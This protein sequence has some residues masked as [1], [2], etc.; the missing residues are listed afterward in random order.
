MK[1]LILGA[2]GQVGRA[3]TKETNSL[4]SIVA[5]GRSEAD[6]SQPHTLAN[7]FKNHKPDIV[8]N[9]AAYTAVDQAE[10]QEEIAKRINATAP[11]VLA[12]AAKRTNAWFIHYSTDYVFDGQKTIPYTETD[13]PNPLNVYGRTKLEGEQ[14]VQAVGGNYL[15]FRTSWVFSNDG[16]NFITKVLELAQTRDSM[17]VI[18]DQ[19]GAPTSANLIAKVTRQAID[20]AK[21]TNSRLL[22]LFHLT[23]SGE[24]SWHNYAQTIVAEAEKNN[25]PLKLGPCDI[26]QVASEHF[27]TPAKRPKNSR[28][29]T[30][31][32]RKAL[33]IDLPMWEKDVLYTIDHLA[34]ERNS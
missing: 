20:T 10:G 22:G 18:N 19:I 28:L 3:L 21:L 24:T 25:W 32:L 4:G 11:G 7:I 29:S 14:A 30:L 33:K 12:E 8:I 2:H 1:I 23:A 31:K 13:V 27:P 26:K 5:L 6:L 16:S 34:R 17:A 9:A 15:V